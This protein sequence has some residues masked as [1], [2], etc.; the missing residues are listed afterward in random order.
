MIS[1]NIRVEIRDKWHRIANALGFAIKN[2]NTIPE[3]YVSLAGADEYEN[4]GSKES[5]FVSVLLREFEAIVIKNAVKD[6][7]IDPAKMKMIFQNG[8]SLVPYIN[9][10]AGRFPREQAMFSTKFVQNTATRKGWVKKEQALKYDM[11]AMRG[12][13]E[14]YGLDST[15]PY[16]W[17]QQL[18]QEGFKEDGTPTD[19]SCQL[20]K[21]TAA[22]RLVS[23][24]YITQHKLFHISD[25]DFSGKVLST[26]REMA[27]YNAVNHGA[28]TPEEILIK[29]RESGL[30]MLA[31]KTKIRIHISSSFDQENFKKK[32]WDLDDNRGYGANPLFEQKKKELLG[33]RF[34]R[35]ERGADTPEFDHKVL[36]ELVEAARSLLIKESEQEPGRFTGKAT[37]RM[38]AKPVR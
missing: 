20:I 14:K 33:K 19:E 37:A 29:M 31:P 5:S 10:K 36:N 4:Q 9:P 32:L 7:K 28:K 26:L 21:E 23:N 24:R 30:W 6:K 17:A 25:D 35:F 22:I 1:E 8:V 12:Q 16:N 34:P 2:Y 27:Y 13:L 15:T 3:G 38:A 18:G 11:P